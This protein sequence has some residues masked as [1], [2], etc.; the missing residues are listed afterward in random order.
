MSNN[1]PS[2]ISDIKKKSND[3]VDFCNKLISLDV[4]DGFDIFLANNKN[5]AEL[6]DLAIRYL[7][8]EA[9][10]RGAVWDEIEKRIDK[11]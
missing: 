11:I 9:L 6:F 5:A 7:D 3:K 2:M 10:D 1:Y 4:D 8:N